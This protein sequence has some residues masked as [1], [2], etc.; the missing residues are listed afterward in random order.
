[1]AHKAK[2]KAP[3]CRKSQNVDFS[4]YCPECKAYWQALQGEVGPTPAS[5]P[6]QDASNL[7]AFPIPAMAAASSIDNDE[8]NSVFERVSRKELLETEVFQH[9]VLGMFAKLNN[10][11]NQFGNSQE[12][13]KERVTSAEE[14]IKALENKVGKKEECAMPLSITIQNLEKSSTNTDTE[15]VK[16]VLLSVN[17][18]GMIIE[19]DVVKVERRNGRPATATHTEKPGIVIRAR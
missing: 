7:A 15:L 2:C 6:N 14:R 8:M 13:V 19:S 1:M 12:E 18:E 16:E 5:N 10:T 11:I 9:A 3:N 17:Y 4:G